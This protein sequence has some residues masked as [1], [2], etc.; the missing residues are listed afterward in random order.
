MLGQI[1]PESNGVAR[2][3]MNRRSLLAIAAAAAIAPRPAWALPSVAGA[4]R[5]N[6]INAHTGERFTGPYRNDNGPIADALK[7]LSYF[8][9]DF[10]C[11]EV[12]GYDVHVLDFL[13]DML[14]AVGETRATVLSAYRTPATNAR[15]AHTMFGVAENSQHL[16]GRA[17]DI[18]LPVRLEEAM[19]RARAMKRGGVG[20]YPN[21]NFIHIDTGPVRNW[22]LAGSGFGRLLFDGKASKYFHE[23]V[24][25]SRNGEFVSHRSGRPL[26]PTDRLALHRLLEQAITLPLRR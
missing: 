22:T 20:W 13:A 1:A 9:R 3:G 25:I 5:L 18:Y 17:L 24:A 8:L 11:G 7:E 15:L 14:E 23:P 10:H 6:L 2:V 19:L 12:T 16:Y 4:R 21:S 26:S